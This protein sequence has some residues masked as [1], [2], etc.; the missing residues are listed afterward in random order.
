MDN[1]TYSYTNLND[2]SVITGDN[3]LKI[4]LPEKRSSIIYEYKKNN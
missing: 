3:K 1:T 4:V 2:E